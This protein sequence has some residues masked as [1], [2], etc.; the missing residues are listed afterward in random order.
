MRGRDARRMQQHDRQRRAEQ[1]A[2]QQPRAEHAD[3]RRHRDGEFGA[4]E[5]PD[6]SQRVELHEPGDRHEDDR[7]EHR[8]RQNPQQTGEEQDDDE[9]DAGRDQTRQRRARAGAF[10][11][12]RLRHAAADRKSAAHPG[13]EVGPADREELLGRVESVAM[14]AAEHPPDRRRFDRGQDEAGQRQRQ[15]RV[16]VGAADQRQRRHRQPARDFAEQRDAAR[17]EMKSRAATILADD[18]E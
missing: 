6:V 11:D 16:D 10:V 15:Q 1:H 4:A 17:V 8:L 14:L 2:V 3:D 5:A 13:G 7:G 18:D 12:E 9:C